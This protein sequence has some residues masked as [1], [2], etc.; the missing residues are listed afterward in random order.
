MV[1]RVDEGRSRLSRDELM[2]ELK[3]RNIGTGVHF[4]AVHL[5]KFYRER[6]GYRPGTLPATEWSSERMCSL[7]LFPAMTEAD[8]DSVIEALEGALAG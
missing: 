5:Q 6:Y 4:R 2:A 8:V 7:P 3:A 1:V